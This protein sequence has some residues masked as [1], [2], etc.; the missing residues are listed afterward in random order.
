MLLNRLFRMS[1]RIRID[2]DRYEIVI[3]PDDFELAKHRKEDGNLILAEHLAILIDTWYAEGQEAYVDKMIELGLI[4]ESFDP[5]I[6]TGDKGF[7]GRL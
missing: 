4:L 6:G 5:S 1:E 7:T 2:S 3:R